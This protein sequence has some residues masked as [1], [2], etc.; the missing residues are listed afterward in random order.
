[1]NGD[2]ERIDQHLDDALYE[3]EGHYQEMMFLCDSAGR[4]AEEARRAEDVEAGIWR[5]REGHPVH[6]SAMTGAHLRNSLAMLRRKGF[7]GERTLNAYLSTPGPGGDMAQVAFAE[8]LDAVL[9]APVN[10][11]VDLLEDELRRR[12]LREVAP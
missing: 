11:Y 1:M 12:G 6:V 8:E 5:T 7:I 9:E 2:Y 3:S 4:E 10:P